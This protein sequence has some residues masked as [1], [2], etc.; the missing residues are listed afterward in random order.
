MHR[1]LPRLQVI[2]RALESPGDFNIEILTAQLS[3]NNTLILS[4][5][6]DNGNTS[7]KTIANSIHVRRCTVAAIFCRLDNSQE[8]RTK[9]RSLMVWWTWN[10]QQGTIRSEVGYD[11]LVALGDLSWSEYEV[12]VPI[13]I[14][15]LPKSNSG[16][17]G[18]AVRWNGHFSDSG[19]NPGKGW[20]NL[21]AYAY[22]RKRDSSEGGPHLMLRTGKNITPG[23]TVT[24]YDVD[25]IQ[26]G[27]TYTFKVRVEDDTSIAAADVNG[28]PGN[29]FFKVWE[30]N[31]TEPNEWQLEIVDGGEYKPE[32]GSVVLVAYNA[33]VSFG[34][35]VVRSLNPV[36]NY[37]VTVTTEGDGKVLLN[38]P[39][40]PEFSGG[41]F[42]SGTTLSLFATP[43][44]DWAFA[45]WSGDVPAGRETDKSLT[46]TVD[47][48]KSLVAQF[49]QTICRLTLTTN[50]VD[51]GGI[52]KQPSQDAFV[53][54]ADATLTALSTPGWEF[55]G[56][57]GDVPIGQEDEN[58][59]TI[60]VDSDKSIAAEFEPANCRLSVNTSPL[61]SGLVAQNPSQQIFVCGDDATLT[62]NPATGWM[63][64]GWEGDVPAGQETVNPLSV[65]V[66]SA[67]SIVAKFEQLYVLTTAVK[68]QGEILRS[69]DTDEFLS[70]ETVTLLASPIDGWVFSEWSGDIPVDEKNREIIVTM[71]Q[72]K[73]IT[74]K[75]TR[76]IY[77]PVVTT[78][79]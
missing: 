67:K 44:T 11:R 19:E 35:V 25:Y 30:T 56:W 29:F 62:A 18:L 50:P 14:N 49:S 51:S 57:S 10:Q 46:I 31:Q 38:S 72:N 32:S 28:S 70:G 42:A 7:S 40:G 78:G 43:E 48:E 26:E 23:S 6:D 1:Y 73:S 55:A 64:V 21:G 68:G 61:D 53:C 58:P 20:W 71:D 22:Y 77:I 12:E 27:K 36:E 13:T 17:I 8:L 9:P 75:F 3:P 24:D 37:D 65:V 16:G 34:E 15:S 4:A 59:L 47:G 74:A 60:A 69:P 33:D 45:S 79:N 39:Q 5:K 54:G 76:L 63:F 52:T 66:D 2:T 41:T